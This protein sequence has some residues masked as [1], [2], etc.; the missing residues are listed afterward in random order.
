M[1]GSG[2][3]RNRAALSGL[4]LRVEGSRVVGIDRQQ[5]EDL[6]GEAV[7]AAHDGERQLFTERAHERSIV[8]HIARHLAA[9]A[10]ARL[11]GWSVDVEYDRWHSAEAIEALKKQLRRNQDSEERDVYPD[12]IIHDRSGSS[13]ERN[14]L[15][16]EVKKEENTG[17]EDDLAKLRAFLGSPFCYQ[18][19]AFLVLPADGGLPYPRWVAAGQP[20][21]ADGAGG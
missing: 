1:T 8:F 17:H 21:T 5:V 18:H 4:I 10:E 3:R 16:V 2:T 15:V 11:P 7:S 13:A 6:L 20:G 9:L 19:A 14:L 12:I